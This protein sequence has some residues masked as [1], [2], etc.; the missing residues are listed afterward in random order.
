MGQTTLWSGPDAP[1]ESNDHD[2]LNAGLNLTVASVPCWPAA[3]R[4]RTD[5]NTATVAAASSVSAQAIESEPVEAEAST[6]VFERLRYGLSRSRGQFTEGLASLVLGKKRLDPV[7]LEAL[8]EQLIMADLGLEA[9]DRVLE[10]LRQRLDRESLAAEGTAMSALKETL[11]ELLADQ[12]QTLDVSRRR[13]TMI[14]WLA[15]M[16]RGKPPRW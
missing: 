2:Y 16:V 7:L 8:E 14:W 15:S 5:P 9:A 3:K 13:P 10:S 4:V 11:V 6:G 1:T 12:E